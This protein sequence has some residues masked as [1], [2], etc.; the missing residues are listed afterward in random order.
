MQQSQPPGL[1]PPPNQQPPHPPETAQ[2]NM[3]QQTQHS[4]PPNSGNGGPPNNQQANGNPMAMNL[5]SQLEAIKMQQKS[6]REQ[7][8]QSE[9]NLSAQHTVI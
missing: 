5:T 3:Q 8:Q 6:L 7:I 1:Y 4:W 9:A 2:D